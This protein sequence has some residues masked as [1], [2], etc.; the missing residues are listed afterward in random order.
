V[1]IIRNNE[2]MWVYMFE[3]ADGPVYFV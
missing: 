2:I 1:K 3:L